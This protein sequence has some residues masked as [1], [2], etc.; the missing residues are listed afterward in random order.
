[1][2]K[3]LEK[4]E[5]RKNEKNVP[6]KYKNENFRPVS[7]CRKFTGTFLLLKNHLVLATANTFVTFFEHRW[8]TAERSA[9]SFPVVQ[10]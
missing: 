1:M 6:E 3:R 10:S 7:V 9:F 2:R 4:Y 5:E 8:Q